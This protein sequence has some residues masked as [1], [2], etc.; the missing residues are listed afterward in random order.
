MLLSNTYTDRK[1]NLKLKKNALTILSGANGAG[2]TTLLNALKAY[3]EEKDY[4][5]L[6]WS[7][8][9]F[10]RGEAHNRLISQPE[11]LAQ[12]AF[13]S[14]GQCISGSLTIFVVSRIRQ[15]AKN[16]KGKKSFYI[17]LDQLDSGLD[18]HTIVK[19]KQFF[20]DMVIP[21]L[22]KQGFSV[23]VVLSANSYECAE[24]EYCVDCTTGKTVKLPS[25]ESFKS[26]IETFYEGE[27]E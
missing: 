19:Y 11:V 7:D 16:H 14:E 13:R 9:M 25:Y 10:G 20:R 1:I 17:L 22:N 4:A 21:D 5:C 27:D 3:C 12:V 2:K 18:A 6:H 23:Y 15:I 8:N 24:G 26:Y